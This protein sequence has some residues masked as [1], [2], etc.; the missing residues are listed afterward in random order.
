MKRTLT[1]LMVVAGMTTAANAQ[2]VRE[3]QHRQQGR[4]VQGVRSGSLAPAETARLERQERA[5]HREIVRD[6]ISGGHLGPIERAHIQR[7]EN[8]LSNEVYRLKHNPRVRP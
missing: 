3:R 5:L 2:T 6:S 7:Q 1:I 4:I 8:R